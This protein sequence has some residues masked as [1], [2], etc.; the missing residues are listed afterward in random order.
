MNVRSHAFFFAS[1]RDSS[2]KK[3]EA[4]A[5]SALGG[6]HNKM[7]DNDA[8]LE[9]HRLDLDLSSTEEPSTGVVDY[10][11]KIRALKNLGATYEAMGKV[12][13]AITLHEQHL[14][15]ATQNDDILGKTDALNCL[16][17]YYQFVPHKTLSR[18]HGIKEDQSMWHNSI[19]FLISRSTTPHDR[20]TRFCY[21]IFTARFISSRIVKFNHTHTQKPRGR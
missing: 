17:K 5:A 10:Q 4:K 9:F 8:A 11:G 7:N 18:S 2:D 1:F 16:G 12:D 15:V 21:F 19:A 20:K 3:G 13:E 14:E 6:V